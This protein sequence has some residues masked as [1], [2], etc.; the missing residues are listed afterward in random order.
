M[1]VTDEDAIVIVIDRHS[2]RLDELA[3]LV[4]LRAEL[5]HE[6]AAIVTRECLHS[7]IVAIDDIQEASMMVERQASW[8]IEQAISMASLFGANRERDS[9]INSFAIEV[10]AHL[11]PIKLSRERGID[12][13]ARE[14]EHC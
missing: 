14:P 10:V 7:I 11:A 6:R 3:W 2:K 8:G 12:R 5:G 4:A 13:D 9:S 1:R